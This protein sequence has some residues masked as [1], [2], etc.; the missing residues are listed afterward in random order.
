MVGTA[1]RTIRRAC[2]GFFFSAS[3]TKAQ[4][5]TLKRFGGPLSLCPTKNLKLHR[6]KLPPM[7]RRNRLSKRKDSADIIH[8]VNAHN[9]LAFI[10]TPP[11]L[12]AVDFANSYCYFDRPKVA[13]NPPRSGVCSWHRCRTTS[14]W[15]H[16][17]KRR[18]RWW[19]Q[20]AR[21]QRHQGLAI[22][23]R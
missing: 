13:T 4:I 1:Y 11:R 9:D 23:R 3:W 12:P 7:E 18:I 14:W 5:D 16:S 6:L 2:G 8:Q 20:P 22:P 15:I 21:I 17:K 10:S 19:R